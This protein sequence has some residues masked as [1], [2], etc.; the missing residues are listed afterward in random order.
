MIRFMASKST[1]FLALECCTFFDFGGSWAL[2]KIVSRH[3]VS[4]VF[5]AGS[6]VKKNTKIHIFYHLRYNILSF[7]IQ[8]TSHIPGPTPRPFPQD[9]LTT[10]MVSLG[11]P[12]TRVTSLTILQCQRSSNASWVTAIDFFSSTPDGHTQMTSE[13]NSTHI[14]VATYK[15][16][17]F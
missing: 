16:S 15:I 7:E 13:P 14:E 11:Y 5:T 2:F 3:S 8:Q 17:A 6:S 9:M 10:C 12:V 1:A 4:R